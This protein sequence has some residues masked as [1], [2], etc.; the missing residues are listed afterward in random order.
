MGRKKARPV[1]S[2][3]AN[4]RRAFKNQDLV[5]GLGLLA[6]VILTYSRA[7]FLGFIWDDDYYVIYNS[8]LRTLSGLWR[9]WTE[10]GVPSVGLKPCRLSHR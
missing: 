7:P 8:T 6:I 5:A 10:L 1:V 3:T 9:I 2:S 4:S